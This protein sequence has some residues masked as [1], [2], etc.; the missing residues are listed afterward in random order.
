MRSFDMIR[1]LDDWGVKFEKDENGD[2]DVKKVH[3]LGTY[4]LPMPEGDD[5][6]KI[7]YRQLRRR[8]F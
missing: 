6:K 5:V 2:Y 3:H 8:R 4:V 7:L 1:E